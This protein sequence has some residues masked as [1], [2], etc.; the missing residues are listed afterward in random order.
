M[1]RWC[2]GSSRRWWCSKANRPEGVRELGH[3][4]P[5]DRR[6]NPR[7]T[8]ETPRWPRATTR[9]LAQRLQR[10]TVT[11]LAPLR[12]QRGVQAF[13]AQQRALAGL[14]EPLVLGKDAQLVG[15]G[16]LA[17]RPRPSRHLRIGMALH[18]VSARPD[19]HSSSCHG[20]AG[21]SLALHSPISARQA[22]HMRLTRRAAQHAELM[23]EHQD[24]QVLTGVIGM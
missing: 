12:D 15:G 1:S 13:A 17:R 18:L 24:L 14:V 6:S 21:S 5:H 7:L 10:A 22:S 3:R 20:L 4:E 8:K 23:L 16:V 11:L 9:I 2:N 19:L